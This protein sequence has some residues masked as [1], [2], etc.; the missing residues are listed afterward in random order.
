[1]IGYAFHPDAFADLDEIWVYIAQNDVD[2]ADRVPADIVRS[3][4]A[5][6][7]DLSRPTVDRECASDLRSC[8]RAKAGVRIAHPTEERTDR[9]SVRPEKCYLCVRNETGWPTNRSFSGNQ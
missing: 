9:E 8:R 2:A 4:A 1:M 3:A 7:R 6:G 5:D